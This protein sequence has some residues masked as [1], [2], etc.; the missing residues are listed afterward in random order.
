MHT[1]EHSYTMIRSCHSII[2][3]IGRNGSS[4]RHV[5]ALQRRYADAAQHAAVDN[6]LELPTECLLPPER[7]PAK[8]VIIIRWSGDWGLSEPSNCTRSERTWLPAQD[9]NAKLRPDANVAGCGTIPSDSACGQRLQNTPSRNYW[10]SCI[11]GGRA[12]T[13]IRALV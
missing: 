10:V 8:K 9:R 13:K 11:D 2:S 5:T 12:L 3:A 1:Q 4:S 6:H 7:G